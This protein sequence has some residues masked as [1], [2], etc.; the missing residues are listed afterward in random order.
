[1]TI[2]DERW[3]LDF[4][5]SKSL[6]YH[7]YRRAFW[8]T[9]DRWSKIVTIVSGTSVLV[10]I[11]G[12]HSVWAFGLA[13]VVAI[14]SAADVVIGFSKSARDHDML[15][16]AFSHLA[17]DMAGTEN[18]TQKDIYSWRRRLLEIEMDEPFIVDLLER[19]C[20]AEEA[21]ARGAELRDEWKLTR[22]QVLTSQLT[23]LPSMFKNQL[24]SR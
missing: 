5:V 2:E 15:Y 23:F 9:I 14:A 24:P 13:I 3:D 21:R 19:R 10:S 18:L 7:S 16:R 8:D 12:D 22:W 11:V 17:Q 1:M 4:T 6:R 20:A